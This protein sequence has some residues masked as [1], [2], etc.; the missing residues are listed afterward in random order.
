[1][2]ESLLNHSTLDSS[3]LELVNAP[4][5]YV[6]LSGGVDSTALLHLLLAWRESRVAVPPLTVIHVNHGMQAAAAAWQAHC[7][8]I[9]SDWGVPVISRAVKVSYSGNGEAAARETRYRVFEEFMQPGAVLFLGHHLDDQVET[10]FLRLM[11]G[12]GVDGLAAIPRSRALHE[13]LL[14]RPL[15]DVARNSI[16]QYALEHG[17]AHVEDP[18]NSDT[19]MDRNFLRAQLLPLLASRWPSYRQTVT[20]ASGHMA[21]TV[22]VLQENLGIPQTVHSVLG[23]LGLALQ[24]LITPSPE[25]A[26]LKLRAWLQLNG[27]QVPDHAAVAEF[28][29]QLREAGSDATPRLA[30][31]AYSLQRYRD[32]VY[33]Q[34]EY[35]R[36]HPLQPLR[37]V[38]GERSEVPGVGDLCLYPVMG[39]GLLLT[40][41]DRPQISWRA[42]GER[43]RPRQRSASTSL[44][45]L[46]QEWGVPPWWRDRVPL[47]YLDGELL[48]VGDLA[49]CKSSR[50]R[51]AATAGEQLW[52]LSWERAVDATFD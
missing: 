28:L 13:G 26:A 6:G 8:R 15:L 25:V 36:E 16:E 10:F 44:K 51:A 52:R 31:S 12:A 17:L 46:L 39:E 5:W 49:L 41:Q 3:L 19:I 43:C 4:H 40:A 1:M 47:L 42:G 21:T 23:D 45:K 29:R 22:R 38:P 11:R 18:S 50:W 30:C 14:V 35:A 27:R 24:E 34:P 9:C 2:S 33:L 20:R 37:L 48:A 7:E 32:A